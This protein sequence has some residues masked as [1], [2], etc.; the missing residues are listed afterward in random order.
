M[1]TCIIVHIIVN[2]HILTHSLHLIHVELCNMVYTLNM[3]FSAALCS[4]CATHSLFTPTNLKCNLAQY[5]ARDRTRE[6]FICIKVA[7]FLNETKCMAEGDD[8]QRFHSSNSLIQFCISNWNKLLHWTLFYL[9][10]SLCYHARKTW[11]KLFIR[12]YKVI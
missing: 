2:L 12:A 4:K 1:E 7:H 8:D 5:L 9:G 3:R 6:K 10:R 11:W